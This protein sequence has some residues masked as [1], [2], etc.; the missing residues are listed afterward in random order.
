MKIII[1]GAQD[2]KGVSQE[3]P[4]GR[5]DQSVW[6][7]NIGVG[8]LH[9]IQISPEVKVRLFEDSAFQ[10]QSS[11]LETD[12]SN[13]GTETNTSSIVIE[14]KNTYSYRLL[15]KHSDKVLE[16]R[17]GSREVGV[18]IVQNPFSGESNQLFEFFILD[19]GYYKI[20][21]RNSGKFLGLQGGNDNDFTK[22]LQQDW[23]NGDHQ[24]WKLEFSGNHHYKIINKLSSKVI[25]VYNERTDNHTTAVQQDYNGTDNQLFRIERV[26]NK[27]LATSYYPEPSKQYAIH[28]KVSGKPIGILSDALTSGSRAEQQTFSTGKLTQYFRFIS[29]GAGN[30]K[31]KNVGSDKYLS[32]P[33]GE[34]Q[35][36]VSVVQEDWSATSNNHQIWKLSL[37]EDGTFMFRVFHSQKVL[38]L[39]ASS[40]DDG[41]YIQQYRWANVENQKFRLKSI[42]TTN[43]L[44]VPL[45]L[46][47][48]HVNKPQSSVGPTADFSYLPWNDGSRDHNPDYA[49]LGEYIEVTPLQ[50]AN[51]RL[52]AGI[53]LHWTLPPALAREV[54][55]ENGDNPLPYVPDKWKVIPI[56]QDGIGELHEETV[57][58]T[59]LHPKNT[60]LNLKHAQIPIATDYG[61]KQQPFRYMGTSTLGDEEPNGPENEKFFN[62]DLTSL[63]YGSMSFAAFYP[64]CR[65]V[66]GHHIPL[67][68]T[69][70]GNLTSVTYFVRATLYEE[71]G[72]YPL[73]KFLND[74]PELNLKNLLES[75]KWPTDGGDP[76]RKII[77]AGT[78]KVQI[79]PNTSVS[80]TVDRA[81]SDIQLALG[82]TGT[83][84]LS[85]YL[86]AELGTQTGIRI[87]MEEQLEAILM[88]DT[89]TGHVADLSLKFLENRHAHGFREISGG[90]RWTLLAQNPKVRPKESFPLQFLNE[91]GKQRFIR[92]IVKSS[93]KPLLAVIGEDQSLTDNFKYQIEALAE[94]SPSEIQE[95]LDNFLQQKPASPSAEQKTFYDALERLKRQ[96][97]WLERIEA[98]AEKLI[99]LGLAQDKYQDADHRIENLKREL[100]GDWYKYMLAKY[101]P[102]ESLEQFDSSDYPNPG[103]AAAWLQYR[104]NTIRTWMGEKGKID[105]QIS[106]S[107]DE[108]PRLTLTEA[109]SLS[110]DLSEKFEALAD[111]TGPAQGNLPGI[112]LVHEPDA[113]FYV[114]NDPVLLITGLDIPEP[115]LHQDP[116]KEAYYLDESEID[117]DSGLLEWMNQKGIPVRENAHW[118]PFI[119]EW[120]VEFLPLVDSTGKNAPQNRFTLKENHAETELISNE[121]YHSAPATTMRGRTFLTP[122]AKARKMQV[123]SEFL[124]TKLPRN[125]TGVLELKEYKNKTNGDSHTAIHADSQDYVFVRG[126][127]FIL[128]EE[129]PGTQPLKLWYN[130]GRNDH[131]LSAT[132]EGRQSAEESGY[133][134]SKVIGYVYEHDGYGRK[135][136]KLFWSLTNLDNITTATE[137]GE[138]AALEAG[139][140]FIRNEGYVMDEEYGRL[141]IRAEEYIRSRQNPYNTND[142]VLTACR[143]FLEL[144]DTKVLSQALGGFTEGMLQLEQHLQP[145]LQDLLGSEDEHN[146]SVALGELIGRESRLS[147]NPAKPFLPL[148]AGSFKL[149]G[150]RV[151]DTWGRYRDLMKK[152]EL[153]PVLSESLLP[154]AGKSAWAGAPLR[155]CQPMRL[156]ANWLAAR[157]Y[158]GKDISLKHIPFASPIVGW[159]GNN[160][161]DRSLMY[162]SA[163]GDALGYFNR[164]GDRKLPPGSDGHAMDIHP[165]LQHVLDHADNNAAWLQGFID[166]TENA[167][168]HIAPHEHQM[169]KGIA[170]LISRPL[171]VVRLRIN[172]ELYGNPVQNRSWESMRE[173]IERMEHG[174]EEVLP[175]WHQ[176][177]LPVR[178]GNYMMLNDGLVGFWQEDGD[179]NHIG[180]LYTMA[181]RTERPDILPHDK[182]TLLWL[183][184]NGESVTLTLLI[185]PRG[186]LHVT[187]GV[188]PVQQ[189]TLRKDLV[190]Q[191][192]ERINAWFF[193]AP[194][195]QP[196]GTKDI[197]YASPSEEPGYE[198]KWLEALNDH[199]AE[200]TDIWKETE[201]FQPAEQKATF[202]EDNELREGWFTLE[203]D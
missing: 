178:L 136:L 65:E 11:E 59:Y 196:K 185:D 62:H 114:P 150:L 174:E 182:E 128:A 13:L 80:Q 34:T 52:Q 86:G 41:A 179:G 96:I 168:A 158:Q 99:A 172:F 131:V 115:Q 24:K 124:M 89:V 201:N 141:A 37:L 21:N 192:T 167:L 165:A 55:L 46:K 127:T 27:R 18:D 153:E 73:N 57:W 120:Q 20:S 64:D 63:G 107:D 151:I 198:W 67:D 108:Q 69:E 139:Y 116:V 194:L 129:R 97:D 66:F 83:E 9:S 171:A 202:G 38:D 39:A 78:V 81:N 130:S 56:Q 162:F 186:S 125:C 75:F 43:T 3:L 6:A 77:L 36:S 1:Y 187:S 109:A 137:A 94:F 88:G 133:D 134:S 51:G 15:A 70:H 12:N 72:A 188:L 200:E 193:Q 28:S 169:H 16:V 25:T 160:P 93:L 159:V 58:S 156:H 138:A 84:A 4:I 181:S 157:K 197:L 195:L 113:P 175:H 112:R 49:P 110:E 199:N 33:I 104:A 119:L 19:D 111:S 105:I 76:P 154:L 8:N 102:P 14:L 98:D 191:A 54:S 132:P 68:A 184:M 2:F 29:L 143:A 95:Q 42:S 87:K 44:V 170:M 26:V 118:E 91:Q 163:G 10:N 101:P 50:S 164:Q 17:K 85:A 122:G 145:S 7:D 60:P 23:I 47:G 48:I 30:Y 117:G 189:L 152:R 203:H 146:F 142:A 74:H 103:E 147:P 190:E 31:I 71:G 176:M 180:P 5:F 40:L 121:G 53:H 126:G 183:P 92:R 123:L 155:V 144:K 166:A 149:I 82:H 161:L 45:L 90:H 140:V 148:R 32:L 177:K 135:P 22:L 100:F 106:T 79:D 61:D 173:N 35:D